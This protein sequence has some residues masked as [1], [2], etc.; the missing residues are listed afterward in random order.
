MRES[1]DAA[2]RAKLSDYMDVDAAID[3]LLAIYALGLRDSGV[4]DLLMA[5]FDGGVWTPSLYDMENAFGLN[6]DGLG[7]DT[8]D[9][10]IPKETGGV[11]T[12]A[13]GSLLWDRI[14]QNFQP[15]LQA[16]YRALRGTVLQN[17][18]VEKQIDT[19]ISAIPAAYY[20]A[21]AQKHPTIP[22]PEGD[23]A[24]QMKQDFARRTALLDQLFGL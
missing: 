20:A 10:F 16:R 5:S 3:Y 17:A 18:A 12:S 4:K 15:E 11:W 1:D 7:Y 21:D 14:V 23:W 9:A 2:F 13:T 6:A 22:R 8:S 19:M 24:Q